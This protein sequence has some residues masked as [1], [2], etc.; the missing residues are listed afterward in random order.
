VRLRSLISAGRASLVSL[1]LLIGCGRTTASPRVENL[2]TVIVLSFDAL[3]DRFLDRDSLPAFRAMMSSGV[4]APFRPEFPSKTF[5]NHYSMATGLPPGK[6]GITIN[7]FF[8]PARGA[9]FRRT[10]ANDGS[11]FGGEP[12]WA[13]AERAGIRTAAYF[14]TGSEAEI[15]GVRPS[16]WF[17]FD[18]TVPDDVKIAQTMQ[19]LR[20]PADKRP[21]L[22][23]MYSGV[24][25]VPGHRYGPDS[26]DAYAAVRAADKTLG[27]LRDSLKQIASMR[28]DLIIVSD[29]G[30]V[31]VP[32]EHDIDLDSLVPAKGALV[33]DEH[34][35]FS[36]WADPANPGLNLDSLAAVYRRVPHTRVFCPGQ[37]PAEWQTEQNRRFGDIFLLADP[38]WEYVTTNPRAVYTLGEHGY[39]PNTP[40]MMGVFLA[41]GPDFKEGVRLAA[42]ENRTLHDL[43]ARLLHLD[44]PRTTTEADFGLK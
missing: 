43:L 6:H 37:F 29:H 40:E 21:Q 26:P 34:A 36:V 10:S 15:G 20:L 9:W 24:V 19:W 16:Y 14:W 13:S 22:I 27:A 33:D 25:D 32:R 38:G 12:I 1:G 30:L 35:T 44:I 18:A 39:D 23:M 7:Q 17:P 28:I 3:G 41:T 11:F 31:Y 8:D 4:R 2:P 42:R 5:P